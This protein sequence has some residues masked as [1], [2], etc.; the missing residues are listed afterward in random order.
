M[1]AEFPS[2]RGVTVDAATL[3]QTAPGES[4][5]TGGAR[6][7]ASG[8][9]PTIPGYELVR[10]LGRGGM[11][12]VYEA[13]QLNARRTVA[14]KM[15]LGGALASGTDLAR[16]RIEAEALGRIHHSGIVQVFDVG[17]ADGVPYF[18]LEYCDGGSLSAYLKHAQP[19]P[20]EAAAAF[21]HLA[22]AVDA[23]HR[24]QVVHRDLKPGN[25][26]LKRREGDAGVGLAAFE[27]K[28]ADFGLAKQLDTP[29]DRTRTNVVMGTPRYMAPEQAAGGSRYVGPAADVHAL[30]AILYE[31]L[32]GRPPFDGETPHD[33]LQQVRNDDPTPARSVNPAIPRDLEV[34]ALKCLRKEPH[35]R[36]PSA[37]DLADDLHRFL[38]GVPIEARPAG[39]AERAIKWARR[40]PTLA[41]AYA[42]GFLVVLLGLFT[43]T[44]A[45]MWTKAE[46]ER[47]A[48]VQARGEAEDARGELQGANTALG[49]ALAEV[50]DLRDQEKRRSYSDQVRNAH[51]DLRRGQFERARVALA[52][53]PEPYRGWEWGFLERQTRMAGRS[54]AAH[55]GQ[56]IHLAI[57]RD[58]SR[59][60]T[61]AFTQA[62]KLWDGDTGM[63]IKSWD[64][65][66]GGI[67]ISSIFHPTED[68]LALVL[69][70][71]VNGKP[72]GV[73]RFVNL[74]TWETTDLVKDQAILI[75]IMAF[76]PDGKLL[77]GIGE[78][79][80]VCVWDWKAGQLVKEWTLPREATWVIFRPDG[81]EVAV[82][83]FGAGVHSYN[84]ETGVDTV[85]PFD[86]PLIGL[87]FHPKT[88][89]PIARSRTA[90]YVE[91]PDGPGKPGRAT[92][93]L[94][95]P[96]KVSGSI[97]YHPEGRWLASGSGPVVQL[98][99]PRGQVTEVVG[100]SDRVISVNFSG[101][102][103]RL[104][105]GSQDGTLYLWDVD[106][107]PGQRRPIELAARGT[108]VSRPVF[109]PDQ[110]R[111][112]YFTGGQLTP[113][114]AFIGD[115]AGKV[116]KPW[117]FGIER[118][119][120]AFSPDLEWLVVATENAR[121]SLL[122]TT[123]ESRTRELSPPTAPM[124]IK[125]ARFSPDGRW[126]AA[127]SDNTLV[128][129]DVAS[130]KVAG[131]VDQIK[132]SPGSLIDAAGDV[133]F[134]PDGTVCAM[135]EASGLFMRSVPDGRVLFKAE[136]PIGMN[137]QLAFS[138]DSRWFTTSSPDRSIRICD[139]KTGSVVQTLSGH[140]GGVYHIAFQP[141]G[142]RLASTGADQALRL[143]DLTSGREVLT[144]EYTD[145]HL[146]HVEFG[147]P[148][149]NRL[150]W[151]RNGNLEVADIS[152]PPGLPMGETPPEKDM[153]LVRPKK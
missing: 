102:G 2:D 100:H 106:K 143:W 38:T 23:A 4:T 121:L 141:G 99:D 134:R 138:D 112:G 27:L 84:V 41:A 85:W 62:A 45:W 83:T 5:A 152:P 29:G 28:V 67:F 130:G 33:V 115:R 56:F 77:A 108:S 11:G 65:P 123:D 81:K 114:R 1:A 37:A 48:A 95:D 72:V 129:W 146:T 109:S 88:G 117:M 3:S 8:T 151:V 59:V 60:L 132:I 47:G 68:L 35:E 50:S 94:L 53:C 66:T 30:G 136:T 153:R 58:G 125:E 75:E 26:L 91:W 17:T 96:N 36:Y 40:K 98:R 51:E 105:T 6:L 63:L 103:K 69:A 107:L 113:I 104:A 149:G 90:Q 139:A 19:N 54:V 122:S 9:L 118:E 80:Q 124:M 93:P 16:F 148:T 127:W 147:G 7:P 31:L 61:T 101:D 111:I 10:E 20:Q 144:L 44:L 133:W 12:V 32:T 15:I 42:L 21:E 39:R 79:K 119:P 89:A 13:V 52:E 86:G 116:I 120:K 73:I 24:R 92:G 18:A 131:R 150:C 82:P 64:P 25:I 137:P 140:A 74:K 78:R 135:A 87:A 71:E 34:I 57:N 70:S 46:R 49:S 43:G 110:S 126:L 22:R 55:G 76:S 128:F 142:R 14:L 97:A 145:S